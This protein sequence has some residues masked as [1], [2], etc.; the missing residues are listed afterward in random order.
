MA[1]SQV[2]TKP[3]TEIIIYNLERKETDED[4]FVSLKLRIENNF[5]EVRENKEG[6]KLNLCEA[7]SV[8]PKHIVRG[9]YEISLTDQTLKVSQDTPTYNANEENTIIICDKTQ[10]HYFPQRIKKLEVD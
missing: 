6:V 5:Y 2:L 8:F 3:V 1:Y 4:I 9:L 7:P 10:F